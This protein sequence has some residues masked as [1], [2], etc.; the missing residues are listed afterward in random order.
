MP[1]TVACPGCRT[2]YR[3]RE[4]SA[5]K[6]VK[7]AK[8]GERFHVPAP[9]DSEAEPAAITATPPRA[10]RQRARDEEDDRPHKKRPRQ[11]DEPAEDRPRKKR[12]RDEEPED[13]DDERPRRQDEDEDA[14]DDPPPKKRK[15]KEKKSHGLLI[16]VFLV[17]MLLWCGGALGT[18]GW[19]INRAVSDARAKLAV[20]AEQAKKHQ[21]FLD[22]NARFDVPGPGV[23]VAFAADGRY[24]HENRLTAADPQLEG[25]GYKLYQIAMIKD[26]TYQI[27]AAGG[28]AAMFLL[29]LAP[30]GRAVARDE[31]GGIFFKAPEAGTYKLVATSFSMRNNHG[32][33]FTLSVH[34]DAPPPAVDDP[35]GERLPHLKV[36]GTGI[37]VV[38]DAGGTY[39]HSGALTARDPR[40]Q[41][42]EFG[43]QPYKLYNIPMEQGKTY[44]ID[45]A[46]T[47]FDC[48]L[49]LLGPNHRTLAMDD[50]GG[51]ELNSRIRYQARATGTH[52]IVA[53][54]L[55]E[56]EVGN[57]TLAVRRV[58]P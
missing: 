23:E 58:A 46:S 34:R 40:L 53:T 21:R 9:D 57:F 52:R 27:D 31:R 6:H 39:K 26:K 35:S 14:D 24:T 13:S 17:V 18:I 48:F 11:E 12:P 54:S 50:D 42:D 3:L 37:G 36:A 15:K 56:D 5:G 1:L 16:G 29:L 38:L 30:D 43:G 4:S 8:C 44:E 41:G 10:P 25:Q 7:C 49:I 22:P 19:S 20:V 47:R 55:D 2:R 32:A 45:M 28:Q 33:D 51:G